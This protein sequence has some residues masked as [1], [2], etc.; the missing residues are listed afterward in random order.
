M[1]QMKSSGSKIMGYI[2]LNIG[3]AII[4]GLWL[5]WWSCPLGTILIAFLFHIGSW[6]SLWMTFSIFLVVHMLIAWQID[7]ANQGILSARIGQLFMNQ[8]PLV[9]I[10]MTGIIAGI[11]SGVG[12]WLGTEIKSK[13][14]KSN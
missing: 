5:P 6:K 3:W 8:K 13:F 10:L 11:P 9:L 2:V 4:A 1:S 7:Q 12:A 14:S